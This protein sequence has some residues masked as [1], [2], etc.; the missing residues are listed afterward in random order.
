MPLKNASMVAHEQAK[1]WRAPELGNLELLRASYRTHS[2]A[3][4]THDE[5][6]IG[7]IEQGA[8][9]FYYR[10]AMHA[11]PAGTIVVIHPG[12]VHDGA[13]G[14]VNGLT[15]RALYPDGALLQRAAADLVGKERGI[16]YFCG[17]AIQ[18][19]ALSRR[20]RSLHVL[21]EE[22]ASPL[23]RESGFL[24]TFTDLIARHAE[25]PLEAS[26]LGQ[27]H[28]AVRQVRDYLEAHPAEQVTLAH[29]AGIARLSPYHLV[30]VFRA[31]LGLPPHAYLT[32]VRVRQAKKLLL[33]GLP[34]SQVALE[35]G[36]V[37][38]SHLTRRFKR[39]VGVTPGQYQHERKNVQDKSVWHAYT[40]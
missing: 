36:F 34:L 39:L 38:Q 11:A 1:L 35:T 20:L 19:E 6:M 28:Q 17:P 23:E 16:P 37:D 7:V 22:S 31:A 13:G 29:L 8:C 26:A 24:L 27:E 40:G 3:R 2:F 30:R 15:Y 5:F 14:A 9:K 33:L 10:G 21:L 4:H 12:E 32:Q 25:R 18:D